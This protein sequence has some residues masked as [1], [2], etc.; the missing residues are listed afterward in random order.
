MIDRRPHAPNGGEPLPDFQP[1]QRKYRHD[2]WTPERQRGFIAALADTGSVRRAANLV[3][4][5]PEGAYYLRRQAGAESFRRAWEAALDFGV[6]R[7]KDLAFERAIEG[8]LVPV[9][10]FGKLVGYRRKMNDRLLMFCLRMNARSRD[11]RRYA[12]SY[13]DPAAPRLTGAPS[14]SPTG[15]GGPAQLMEGVLSPVPLSLTTPLPTEA[16]Q[17]DDQAA[18]IRGFDPV[19]LSLAQIESLEALLADAAAAKRA[20]GQHPAADP[21][22]PFVSEADG[23]H[24]L[25]SGVEEAATGAYFQPEHEADWTMLDEAGLKEVAA[26]DEAVAQVTA[27]REAAHRAALVEIA[28]EAGMAVPAE[29]EA[30]LERERE[31]PSPRT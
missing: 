31:E 2:G 23:A 18:L 9:M 13:F 25:E 8:D 6:Q 1:V 26:I 28:R 21:D 7:L 29:I 22:V 14:S 16:E 4:M 30:A 19:E 17:A 12:Q 20:L 24:L 27:A 5:T 11:G 3:N 10:S 15:G